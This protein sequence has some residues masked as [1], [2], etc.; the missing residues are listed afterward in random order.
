MGPPNRL[1]PALN[2]TNPVPTAPATPRKRGVLGFLFKTTLGCVAFAVGSLVVLVLLLPTMLSGIVASGVADAFDSGRQGRLE[3]GS[4]KLAWFGEQSLR[5]VRLL[6]PSGAQVAR[7]SATLPSLWKLVRSGGTRLGTIVVDVEADLAA[8]DAGTT[9]LQRALAPRDGP[10]TSRTDSSD[11][12]SDFDV[13]E[14]LRDLDA[15][16]RV[17][18]KRLAWSDADTRRLGRPFA[19]EDGVAS[20]SAKPGSPLVLLVTGRIAGEQPG[21]LRID[22]TVHGPVDVS[23]RWP[24]GRTEAKGR[25]EGFSTALVDGLSGLS[26]DLVEVLGPT[27]ALRFD[28][29]AQSA[30][31]GAANLELDGVNADVAIHA[32]LADGEITGGEQPFL[33]ATTPMPRGILERVLRAKLP[34]DA[35]VSFAEAGKS[36][37]VRV[38]KLRI[39]LPD[40]SARDLASL[41]PTLEK[42]ELDLEVD[43]PGS[44]R[45]ETDALRAAQVT[46]G[47]S[48]MKLTARAA[49][50]QPLVAH[51]EA[52]LDAGAPGLVRVDATVP[53]AFTLLAGGP[54]PR[55]D[56]K[57][58]VDGL[59]TLA[60]GELAGQGA[61]I[62]S[63]IGPTVRVEIEARQAN[64][65]GG[66][67]QVRVKSAQLDTH[68]LGR[69]AEG[70]LTLDPTSPAVIT[71]TPTAA[72]VAAEIG[73]RLPAGSDF[74]LEGDATITIPALSVR[75]RAARTT[76]FAGVDLL[77]ESLLLRAIVTLPNV[78]WSSAETLASSEPVRLRDGRLE[79]ALAAGGPPTVNF[80]A[81]I[82]LNTS[83]S[84]TALLAIDARPR[85]TLSQLAQGTSPSGSVALQITGLD[86]KAIEGVLGRGDQVAPF[87]GPKVDVDLRVD[88][89]L[90]TSGSIDLAVRG[91]TGRVGAKGRI[92]DGRFLAQGEEGLDAVLQVTPELLRARL[93]PSL[94]AGTRVELANAGSTGV[95]TTSITVALRDFETPL[96]AP[97]FARRL[98]ATSAK[99][100]V[101]LPDLVYVDAATEAA[102]RPVVVRGARLTTALSPS[103]KPM[104]R[105]I[106]QVEDTPPGRIDVDVTALDPLE[107]LQDEDAWKKFRASARIHAE[108]VP[109]AIVDALAGQDGLLV[110]ALGPRLLVDVQAPDI[111]LDRGAFTGRFESGEHRVLLA[112]KFE[113]GALVVES[114]DG[115][116]ADV[117]L[118]PLVMDRIVGK[119]LPILGKAKFLANVGEEQLTKSADL[120]PFR[121]NSSDVNFALGSDLSKLSGVFRIDLGTL[122]FRGLPMLDQLG[123]ALDAAEVRLPAFTVPIQD[124]VALYDK[125]PIRIAGRDV[126]FDGSV[127]L[128]DG[129]M[130]LATQLP[131][132]LFGKKFERELGKIREFVPLDTAIPI[133]ISGTWN[134]P[135][136]DFQKGFVEGLIE[137][138]AGT[139]LEEKAG[140]LLDDLFGGK[141]K[142]KEKKDG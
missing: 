93:G 83:A 112:G 109:T 116:D 25:I 56:L 29:D 24:L 65:E 140:D 91:S 78:A 37:T 100:D 132:A 72:F 117:A 125:L 77:L 141:K 94:P 104:L 135:R 58:E 3:I 36:W 97:D 1:E 63:A 122:S 75:L 124:G 50:G 52:A 32:R 82:A 120:A 53:D 130:T 28:V 55:L 44:V 96:D 8:D 142:K 60:L 74:E 81:G 133:V 107:K 92:E 123:L 118:G 99:L 115:L 108:N 121:V 39:P 2:A 119:L 67:V 23:A 54:I 22:A 6:D 103:T 59:S 68:I 131:L 76:E 138:A 38:P 88:G 47:I 19:I 98:A 70:V 129:E 30:E 84:A 17:N 105:F 9:N 137:K 41:R 13:A 57:A 89:A 43:L 139:F 10:S 34:P 11:G 14:F 12:E 7:A 51:F 95:A 62:A 79:L 80:V 87:F 4:A 46:A 48:A 21:T 45:I 106:A 90:P 111:A 16:V 27:F 110:E 86:T 15:D 127:R 71:W 128:T 61:R 136:V 31:R 18:L 64:L 33:T 126:L 114:A 73:T 102:H 26:G 134:K 5:D 69:I 20:V 101:A 85:E 113:D 49:P 66:D 35:T 42:A 40:P